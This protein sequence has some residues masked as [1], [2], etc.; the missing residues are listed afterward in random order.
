MISKE[1]IYKLKNNIDTL[2][3][4]INID[5]LKIEIDELKLHASSEAINNNFESSGKLFQ[6]AREK[7][8]LYNNIIILCREINDIVNSL[9][10]SELFDIIEIS[11]L[12]LFK[13]YKEVKQS[14]LYTDEGD[15]LDCLIKITAGA[16]GTEAQDLSLIH[17]CISNRS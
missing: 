7:E 1:D 13:L 14:L 10:N 8:T 17:I 9:S 12:G 11:Y 5:N 16:G 3:S 6:Q 2:S 4:S 15:N